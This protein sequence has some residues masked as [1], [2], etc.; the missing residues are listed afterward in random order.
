MC[1]FVILFCSVFCY[2]FPYCRWGKPWANILFNSPPPGMAWR[3]LKN[4][5]QIILLSTESFCRARTQ[6]RNQN[7][8]F[9]EQER[10]C[11]FFCHLLCTILLFWKQKSWTTTWTKQEMLSKNLRLLSKNVRLLSKKLVCWARF[12]CFIR[13]FLFDVLASKHHHE[14]RSCVHFRIPGKHNHSNLRGPQ[15]AWRFSAFEDD[16]KAQ[17]PSNLS[18][19]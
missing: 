9:A 12:F 19:T 17:S 13:G 3:R 1:C 11:L 7:K 5:E 16:T 15:V 10:T 8:E 4:L 6:K 2:M 14:V 18:E